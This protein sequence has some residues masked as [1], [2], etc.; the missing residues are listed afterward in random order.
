MREL[1]PIRKEQTNTV[2]SIENNGL[3][4]VNEV[5]SLLQISARSVWTRVSKGEFPAPIYIGKLARWRR[6]TINGWLDAKE[7]DA[8]KEQERLAKIAY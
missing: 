6:E 5:A 7:A 3:L 2:T 4:K 8:L 1:V